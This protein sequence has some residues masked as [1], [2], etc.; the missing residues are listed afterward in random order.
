MEEML[1][2]KSVEA[3]KKALAN[4]KPAVLGVANTECYACVNRRQI[5]NGVAILGQKPEG[6]FDPT[7]TA[8][9]FK[10]VDGENIAT[11]IHYAGH[12]TVCGSGTE[13][14]KNLS[15]TRDWPTYMY[16]AVEEL[17]GAPCLYINGAEGDIG[18]RLSNGLT[19]ADESYLEEVGSVA[20]KDAVRAVESIKEFTG[21]KL[22][23]YRDSIFLPM[24]EPPL[25]EDI[26][27]EMETV[28]A[29]I[30]EINQL[31]VVGS[32]EAG[33]RACNELRLAK[34]NA[35]KEVYDKG[36][37]FDKG[38][39]LPQTI[40]A[41]ND[42]AMVPFPF[43]PFNLL[44]Q[45]LRKESPFAETLL[46]GMTNGSEGYLPTE[47]ELPYGGYE[48]DSF[49]S[50]QLPGFVDWVDKEIVKENVRILNKML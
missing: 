31:E 28:T 40:V 26:I 42:L 49:R 32:E 46:F 37:T 20:A 5:E 15:I 23:V 35:M 11:I 21:P 33:V 19:T 14:G 36:E 12:G 39:E 30:D 25:Y 17:T 4:L 34:L 9:L 41:L 1:V 27:K 24:I 10:T 2:G 50:R 8:L 16:D 45:N 6:P 38:V 3:V 44:A 18:P 47:D 48:V 13:G 7:M 29:V 22:R 43:E